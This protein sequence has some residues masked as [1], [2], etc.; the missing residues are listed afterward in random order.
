MSPTPSSVLPRLLL[1]LSLCGACASHSGA[2]STNP[3]AAQAVDNTQ[4]STSLAPAT[5]PAPSRC[6]QYPDRGKYW[7][8]V[9][10]DGDEQEFREGWPI[11]DNGYRSCGPG[12]AVQDGRLSAAGCAERAATKRSCVFVLGDRVGYFDR[13]GQQ[14]DLT[15]VDMKLQPTAAGVDGTLRS[16]EP[17]PGRSTPLLIQFHLTRCP[18][19]EGGMQ[20][21]SDCQ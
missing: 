4:T 13:A 14:H 19:Q 9:C 1:T 5:T 21:N 10:G 3:T 11:S 2:E 15:A 18:W 20:D 16:A 17:L 8:T 6:D 12:G 7:I